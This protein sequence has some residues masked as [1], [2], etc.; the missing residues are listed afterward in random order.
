MSDPVAS[1][2]DDVDIRAVVSRLARPRAGGGYVIERAAILAAGS[3]SAVIEGWILDHAGRPERT[4]SPA[5]GGL[6]SARLD[7]AGASN[8]L[9]RRFLLPPGALDVAH[10]SSN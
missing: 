4:A 10:E 7:D 3:D 5:G 9:P 6:H 2:I 8:R 1:G